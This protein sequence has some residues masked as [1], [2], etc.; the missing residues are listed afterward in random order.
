MDPITL[1]GNPNQMLRELLRQS[2]LPVDGKKARL[3][4][5]LIGNSILAEKKINSEKVLVLSYDDRHNWGKLFLEEMKEIKGVNCSLFNTADEVPDA[6]NVFVYIHPD[7]TINRENDRIII[8]ALQNHTKTTFMPTLKELFLYDEKIGQSKE[9]ASWLPKTWFFTDF[10]CA[11]RQISLMDFPFI[12]KSNEGAA[13][14]N[15]RFIADKRNAELELKTVFSEKGL[16]RHDNRKIGLVQQGYVLW[17]EFLPNNNNDWRVI[18]MNKKYAWVLKRHNR[19][20]VPFA[21]GSGNIEQIEKLNPMIEDIL[22]FTLDF[23]NEFDYNFTGV[24]IVINKDGEYKLLETT[25]G[26]ASPGY[27]ECKVFIRNETG[28]WAPSIFKGKD[29]WLIAALSMDCL[30][31]QKM[32]N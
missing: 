15:I 18:M 6:E 30:I 23:V 12:S 28:E 3:I 22:N 26:W 9:Y 25:T 4:T 29:Q 13:S 32:D 27:T 10:D 7:H 11:Y 21:S 8:E 5:R 20:N 17:Q 16:P 19:P 24:D 14:S 2:N 1:Q 31:K